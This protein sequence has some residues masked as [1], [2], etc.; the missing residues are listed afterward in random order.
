MNPAEQAAHKEN[1]IGINARSAG[2]PCCYGRTRAEPRRTGITHA[3]T[4]G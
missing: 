2:T 1:E 3:F 4:N